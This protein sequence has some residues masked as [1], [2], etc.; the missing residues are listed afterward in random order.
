MVR[1]GHGEPRARWRSDDGAVATKQNTTLPWLDKRGKMVRV[2]EVTMAELLVNLIGHWCCDDSSRAGEARWRQWRA[3]CFSG[4]CESERG[5]GSERERCRWACCG[6]NEALPSQTGGART[7]V[8]LPDSER[9]LRRL[10]TTGLPKS[11]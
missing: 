3:R 10:A 7:D 6:G 9:G 11:A 4:G 8:W 5:R 1:H 2:E